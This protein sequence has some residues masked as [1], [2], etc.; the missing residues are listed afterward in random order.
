MAD[1]F[2]LTKLLREEQG[3]GVLGKRKKRGGK[4]KRNWNF[5]D[6]PFQ[7]ASVNRMQKIFQ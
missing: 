2:A 3:T 1:E 4:K 7:G 6:H 5:E